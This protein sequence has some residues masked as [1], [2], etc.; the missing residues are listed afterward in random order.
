MFGTTISQFFVRQVKN[1]HFLFSEGDFNLWKWEMIHKRIFVDYYWLQAC[2]SFLNL[3]LVLILTFTQSST[4]IGRIIR[5]HGGNGTPIFLG[6]LEDNVY[7]SVHFQA[8]L[9]VSGQYKILH[10]LASD[11]FPPLDA[12]QTNMLPEHVN[13]HVPVR[14][15]PETMISRLSSTCFESPLHNSTKRRCEDLEDLNV[16]NKKLNVTKCHICQFSLEKR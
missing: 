2:A 4:E 9:S 14:N 6:Y 16:S 10:Y 15:I 5:I 7:T 11:K 13:W 8:I 3:D 12:T 1:G